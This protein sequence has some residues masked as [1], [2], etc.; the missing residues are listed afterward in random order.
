MIHLHKAVGAS[1]QDN[2]V[3]AFE[4]TFKNINKKGQSHLQTLSSMGD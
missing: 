4:V 2:E 1:R 3:S